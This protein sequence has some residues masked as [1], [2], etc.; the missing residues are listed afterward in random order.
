MNR[1][2]LS[3]L[4]CLL[5]VL[6]LVIGCGGEKKYAVSGSVSYKGETVEDGT[7]SFVPADTSLSPDGCA[8]THGQYSCKV[9]PGKHTVKIAAVKELPPRKGEDPNIKNYKDLIPKKYNTESTITIEVNGL[10]KKDFILE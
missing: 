5:A 2:Q 1:I 3:G 7:I 4:F 9:R 10:T 8:I 6:V